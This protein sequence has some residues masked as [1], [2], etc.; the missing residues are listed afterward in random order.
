MSKTNLVPVPGKRVAVLAREDA[1][2]S[3]FAALGLHEADAHVIRHADGIVDERVIRSLALSQNL[4]ETEGIIVLDLEGDVRAGVEK[5]K[6]SASIPRTDS[7][8][9]FAYEAGSGAL[10]EVA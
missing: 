9:G 7:V 1:R 4:F 5:I 3:P 2:L 6:A 10:H 8:R